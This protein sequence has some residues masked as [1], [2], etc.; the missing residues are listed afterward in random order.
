MSMSQDHLFE[1]AL[2]LSQDQRANLAFQ[3]LRSLDPPGEEIPVEEF[4][5]ELRD[6]VKGYRRGDVTSS[7][8]EEARSIIQQ[9]LSKGS[10]S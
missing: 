8:L 7:S 9:R 2:S 3:L 10:A 1:T 4:G 6:R 5:N